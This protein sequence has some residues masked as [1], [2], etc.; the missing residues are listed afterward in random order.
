MNQA[1][2]RWRW[3]CCRHRTRRSDTTPPAAGVTYLRTSGL[4]KRWPGWVGRDARV[5]LRIDGHV[6]EGELQPLDD[7]E[8]I[9]L[10]LAAYGEKYELTQMPRDGR[11]WQFVP[12]ASEVS[13]AAPR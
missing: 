6:Y 4:T 13:G 9:E 3:I 5:R 2:M 10:L 1:V 8:R 11:Y 7:P 12:A